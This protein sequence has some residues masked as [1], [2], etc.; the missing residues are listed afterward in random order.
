[1]LYGTPS[2][3]VIKARR[4]LFVMPVTA[5]SVLA[6]A[7]ARAM[8]RGSPNRSPGALRPSCVRV[9]CDTRAKAGLSKTHPWP[10]F[11]VSSSRAL[12]ARARDWSSGRWCRRRAQPSFLGCVDHGLDPE[13]PAVLQILLHS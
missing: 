10:T 1:M 5:Y 9:G 6:R 13:G 12:I 11:S 7:P 3:P 8:T 2:R 4:L